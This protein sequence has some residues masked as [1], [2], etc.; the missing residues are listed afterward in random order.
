MDIRV[1]D[2]QILHGLEKHAVSPQNL[3]TDFPDCPRCRK[4]IR[5]YH[6]PLWRY[7]P[8]LASLTTAILIF[9][10]RD[11]ADPPDMVTTFLSAYALFFLSTTIVVWKLEMHAQRKAHLMILRDMRPTAR[12]LRSIVNLMGRIDESVNGPYGRLAEIMV[13]MADALLQRA[14]A[15]QY[16]LLKNDGDKSYRAELLSAIGHARELQQTI[17]QYSEEA[18]RNLKSCLARTE[19]MACEASHIGQVDINDAIGELAALADET[20]LLAAASEMY[21]ETEA[22]FMRL[23][24]VCE[25]P[26]LRTRFQKALAPQLDHATAL[27]AL[28]NLVSQLP[29]IP[30]S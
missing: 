27:D 19:T 6:Q 28:E 26:D 21:T 23:N 18:E 1:A 12:M 14:M 5:H 7:V 29:P 4:R 3:D 20:R 10:L 15:S 11:Q 2:P 9:L 16:E 22:W 13:N 17:A 25:D 24:E 8:M 30:A